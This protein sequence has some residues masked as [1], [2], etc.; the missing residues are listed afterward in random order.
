MV[1]VL[2]FDY[3]LCLMLDGPVIPVGMIYHDGGQ[4]LIPATYAGPILVSAVKI[5]GYLGREQILA[6]TGA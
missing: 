3:F 4:H 1:V 6:N 2:L 5:F